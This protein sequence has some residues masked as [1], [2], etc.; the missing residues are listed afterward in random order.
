VVLVALETELAVEAEALERL[1]VLPQEIPE[2]KAATA[3]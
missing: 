2:E 1:A 3:V